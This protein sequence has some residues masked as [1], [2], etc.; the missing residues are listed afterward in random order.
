MGFV[1]R[2]CSNA[3]KIT[4]DQL[5]E[6][7]REFLADIIAE[8]LMNDIPK[9]MVLNWDQTALQ[10]IPTGNWTMHEKGAKTT[11]IVHSDDKRQITGVFAVTLTGEYLCPQL[12]FKG[13]TPRCHPKVE[14][15][16]GWDIWHSQNH[17]SPEET[18]KR[19]VTNIINPFLNEKR[20]EL[21]L[22]DTHPALAIFDCF[23]YFMF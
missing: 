2:K 10:Y 15:P 8:V 23:Q 20:K 13:T 16:E 9:H 21:Q 14:S 7:R 19:Y 4:V 1:K 22:S 11:P 3:G 18:M 12:I 5:E 17:W 6:R